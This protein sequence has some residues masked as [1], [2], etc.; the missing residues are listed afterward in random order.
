M[1]LGDVYSFGRTVLLAVVVLGLTVPLLA[2]LLTPAVYYVEAPGRVQIHVKAHREPIEL[3]CPRFQVSADRMALTGDYAGRDSVVTGAFEHVLLRGVRA[4]GQVKIDVP[5]DAEN[6][7]AVVLIESGDHLIVPNAFIHKADSTV[8]RTIATERGNL[9]IEVKWYG[10]VDIPN[11]PLVSVTH[12]GKPTP[13]RFSGFG[14][15]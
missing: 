8:S 14:L 1:T 15:I 3:A 10:A 12:N 5:G 11:P 6:A 9:M 2:Y 7:S 13:R 4:V